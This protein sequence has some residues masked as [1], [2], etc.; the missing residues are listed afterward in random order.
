MKKTLIIGTIVVILI[1]I[2]QIVI[3]D[4]KI[5][6]LT[7]ERD[8]F[9]ENTET[10]LEDC[11]SFKVRDSLNAA[12]VGVLELTIREFEKCRAED[13]ALVKDLTKKNRD[14]DALSRAQAQTIINLRNT[15]RD[16]VIRRDSVFI[17]AKSVHCGDQ[18]YTF[19]G[20]LTDD[21]FTGTLHSWDEIV[22]TETVRYKKILFWKTKKVIDRDL[23]AVSKNPHTQIIGLE[24]IMIDK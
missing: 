2:S 22:L 21:E 8:R 7:A 12:K 1:L 5:E 6:Q 16:T 23:N 3:Q 11:Q 19:D 18:W 14:L 13:A 15:P 10:L 24:H 20:L 4:R 9:K 17:S